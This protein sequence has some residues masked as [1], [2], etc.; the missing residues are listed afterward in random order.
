MRFDRA[1]P[2]LQVLDTSLG[3][4]REQCIN[5][6]RSLEHPYA[7]LQ[8]YEECHCGTT[9]D[10]HGKADESEC[11]FLCTGSSDE[12]CG[13]HLKLSVYKT[14]EHIY[15]YI[16]IFGFQDFPPIRGLQTFPTSY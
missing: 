16:H 11:D 3:K 1:L 9:Y 4:L 14:C 6:C 15:A 13:G 10:K 7:G 12:I 8:F 2:A 5:I